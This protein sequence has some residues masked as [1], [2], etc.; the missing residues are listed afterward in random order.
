MLVGNKSKKD[1]KRVLTYEF[2]KKLSLRMFERAV[3]F[4]EICVCDERGVEKACIALVEEMK[5][6][7]CSL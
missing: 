5:R 2:G 7:K 6:V 3:P 4:F 1:R